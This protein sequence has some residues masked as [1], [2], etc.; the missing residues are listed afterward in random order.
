MSQRKLASSNSNLSL[1]CANRKQ[2]L[3]ENLETIF[4]L[5]IEECAQPSKT[6]SKQRSW[7]QSSVDFTKIQSIK[8]KSTTAFQEQ[9]TGNNDRVLQAIRSA[10]TLIESTTPFASCPQ[11]RHSEAEA[12][13]DIPVLSRRCAV[14]NIIT[15]F[16]AAEGSE[17]DSFDTLEPQ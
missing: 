1:A 7:I 17:I 9:A 15:Y 8:T 2:N 6:S 13:T 12:L 5:N 4:E 16:A 10:I 3:L 14:P 11:S